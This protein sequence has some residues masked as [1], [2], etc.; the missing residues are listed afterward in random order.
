MPVLMLTLGLLVFYGNLKLIKS[1]YKFF[2]FRP[3]LL[4]SILFITLLW[5]CSTNSKYNYAIKDFRKCLQ[6]HLIEIVSKGIVMFYDSSLRHMAAD[7]ELVQLSQSEH[8]VLRA[9]AFREMLHRNSFNHFDIVMNHLDDTAI[10]ETDAGEFGIW[11]R[12]VSDDILYEAEWKTKDEKS[13][14]IEQVLSKHNYLQSAYIILEQL[15]A[16]EKYHASIK[17]MATRPRRLSDD[18]YELGFSDIEHALY[19]L[20][21]FKKQ[22][23]VIIIKN[24]MLQNVWKLSDMSFKLMK[25]FPDTIYFDVLQSYHRRQFYKFSGNRPGGFSGYL[26]DRA[27]PEDFIQAL[28]AQQNDQ[29]AN[30]LDTM[31]NRLPLQTCLPDRENV[32]SEVIM[33]IWEHPCPAYATLREKIETKAEE[34]LKRRISI[35]I[36]PSYQILADTTA[37]KIRWYP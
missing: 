3:K 21:K 9:S 28:V 31:L 1:Y 30:L 13:R 34:I 33:A 6:P 16:Q 25:E 14:T 2:M 36:D 26:A 15:E 17:E 32:I 23:D 10:V 5:S 22:D 29:S 35:P 4:L 20:A 11:S 27:A 37:R 8:P 24:K 12:T 18:G 19:G 7:K